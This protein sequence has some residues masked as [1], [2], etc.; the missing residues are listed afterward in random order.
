MNSTLARISFGLAAALFLWAVILQFN[1]EQAVVWTTLYLV[2]SGFTAAGA[3]GRPP[4]LPLLGVFGSGCA[5]YAAVLGYFVATGDATPMF[6]TP[7]TG[8]RTLFEWKETREI[9]GLAIVVVTMIALALYGER[10]GGEPGRRT[11]AS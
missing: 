8:E 5:V 7:A 10:T 11:D 9:G 3:A 6:E 1:D 4:S 2:A